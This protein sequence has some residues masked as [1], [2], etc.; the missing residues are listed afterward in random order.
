MVVVVVGN[1]VEKLGKVV[2]GGGGGSWVPEGLL[3]ELRG[4]GVVPEAP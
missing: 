1:E 3:L 2:A 4:A